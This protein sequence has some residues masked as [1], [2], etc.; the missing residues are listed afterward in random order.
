MSGRVIDLERITSEQ[1]I[2]HDHLDKGINLETDVA[3]VSR[4]ILDN[5]VY[6]DEVGRFRCQNSRKAIIADIELLHAFQ[7]KSLNVPSFLEARPRAKLRFNPHT[8]HAAIV[9]TGGLAPGLHCVIHSIVKRHCHTYGIYQ[10]SGRI[11]GVYN[12]FKGLCNLADNLV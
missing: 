5:E 4:P 3:E 11:Y 12:S 1:S 9:T 8:V 2:L 6:E 10:D 7:Q